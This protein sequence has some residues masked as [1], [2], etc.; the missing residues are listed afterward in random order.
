MYG[1]SAAAVIGLV[2]GLVAASAVHLAGT[3]NAGLPKTLGGRWIT[4]T[5]SIPPFAIP[6]MGEQS[7][8]Y[9]LAIRPYQSGGTLVRP[10]RRACPVGTT[11]YSGPA[12]PFSCLAVYSDNANGGHPVGLRQGRPDPAGFG[13]LHVITDHN[14]DELSIATTITNNAG[15]IAQGNNRFLYGMRYEIAGVGLIAVEVI[16]DRSPSNAAP[17]AFSLGV[18]TAYC[19]GMT[20]CPD[21]VDQS[22]E[23]ST[24]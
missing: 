22:I 11:N 19:V 3:A 10:I 13:L 20:R 21:E 18:V 2:L 14:L 8:D 5:E 7:P 15:G 1:K 12:Q 16:E 23:L 17:D 4:Y 24:E 9:S 6:T